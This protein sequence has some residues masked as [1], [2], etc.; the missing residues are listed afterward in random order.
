MP[1]DEYEKN[2]KVTPLKVYMPMGT[3]FGP[4]NMN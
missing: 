2:I 1:N 3:R 4:V